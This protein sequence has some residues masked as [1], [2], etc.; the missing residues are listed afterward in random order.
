MTK[1]KF[2]MLDINV[3]KYFL[4]FIFLYSCSPTLDTKLKKASQAKCLAPSVNYYALGARHGLTDY[5]TVT[6]IIKYG[7]TKHINLSDKC[8][9]TQALIKAL[10]FT[11]DNEHLTW[12]NNSTKISGKIKILKTHFYNNPE[13][14]NIAYQGCR[15]YLSFLTIQNK[16]YGTKWRAC[17]MRVKNTHDHKYGMYI[18]DKYHGYNVAF[19]GWFF[20]EMKFIESKY[21]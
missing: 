15:D 9:H 19:G 7:F 11:E 4:V 1:N 6:K 13:S 14:P 3:L 21:Q 18:G 10:F 8:R 12:V 5:N 16:T 17:P 20:Y 2:Y